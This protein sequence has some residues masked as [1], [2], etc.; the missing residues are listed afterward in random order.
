MTGAT[1][2]VGSHL[3][4]LLRNCG[5]HV[6]AFVRD[7]SA[8]DRLRLLDVCCATA[9]LD[10]V[11]SLTRACNGVE[12]LFHLAGAVD[13]ENDWERF[14]LVNVEGTR[15]VVAAALRAG[16]PRLVHTSS[17]VAVGAN[18]RPLPLD[19]ASTWNLGRFRVPYVTTKRQGEELALQSSCQKLHVVAVNPACVIGPGD[20]SK[21]EFGTLCYRFWRGRIP[22]HFGGGHNFV[23]VRDVAMG[24]LLAAERGRPGERYILGGVNRTQNSF[25]GDLTRVADRSIFRV[26]LPRGVGQVAA[27][28]A[29]CAPRKGRRSYLT[30]CQA[31]LLSLFFFYDSQKAA[32][33]LGYQPRDFIQT[34]TETHRFWVHQKA[35]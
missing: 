27:M 15:N 34:A 29:S 17:I 22:F 23:D 13:F 20:F 30:A 21:S 6:T 9:E 31:R 5:A 35:A 8:C 14:H 19:E 2:F 3:A 16:V 24:H 32:Q 18:D 11:D 1:G 25:F 33:E 7:R 10:D 26:W 12:Y 4:T 28:L